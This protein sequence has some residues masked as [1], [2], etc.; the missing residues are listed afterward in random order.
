MPQP[1]SRGARPPRSGGARPRRPGRPRPPPG[2]SP[3]RAPPGS[4]TCR[5]RRRGRRPAGAALRRS[6]RKLAAETKRSIGES[7]AAE[8][9]ASEPVSQA[10][11]AFRATRN[12]AAATAT[13]GVRRGSS[14]DSGRVLGKQRPGVDER[15]LLLHGQLGRRAG[16]PAGGAGSRAPRPPSRAGTR[17]RA[18]ARKSWLSQLSG[19]RATARR[20]SETALSRSTQPVTN[21]TLGAS[22]WSRPRMRW[23]PAS[24]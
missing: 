9:R 12:A 14:V 18:S 8:T 4:R 5:G 16:G 13:S 6:T 11:A 19:P 24:S 7:R 3:A 2:T 15:P 10:P 20:S 23:P 22:V 1:V 21:G 17:S